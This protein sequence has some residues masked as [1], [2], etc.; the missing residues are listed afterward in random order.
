MALL[1]DEHDRAA[2]T[3]LDGS[4][5]EVSQTREKVQEALAKV[6]NTPEIPRW[7]PWSRLQH[8]TEKAL[9]AKAMG[10]IDD[11]L[12]WLEKWEGSSATSDRHAMPPK[13]SNGFKKLLIA[14]EQAV[15]SDDAT[16]AYLWSLEGRLR[17][18][19]HDMAPEPYALLEIKN[20]AAQEDGD[21][22]DYLQDLRDIVSRYTVE[23]PPRVPPKDVLVLRMQSLAHGHRHERAKAAR[24]H[25]LLWTVSL[26]LSL[27][28]PALAATIAWLPVD[29]VDFDWWEI[30]AALV[31]G[32][33]GGSLSGMRM[34][35]DQ[36]ERL[37]QMDS[38]AA[39]VWAQVAAAAGLGLLALILLETGVLPQIGSSSAWDGLIYAFLAGF[40]EPFAIQAVSRLAG[41]T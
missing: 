4:G 41:Q 24:R 21:P 27:L 12:F 29:G 35:R 1:L 7:R 15:G 25:Q 28:V 40:S 6:E 10:R 17:D 37:S 34:L 2:A 30:A 16:E 26:V 14:V 33:F 13:P 39:A 18:A 31:L 20:H 11:R 36:L 19:Y 23:P 9:R 5:T 32:A 22:S 3:P 38:F 8:E